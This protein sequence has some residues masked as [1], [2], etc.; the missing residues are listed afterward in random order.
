MARGELL[1]WLGFARATEFRFGYYVDDQ[2]PQ[3]RLNGMAVSRVRKDKVVNG[4]I[5]KYQ[6]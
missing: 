1:D 5:A 4:G 2:Y 3:L 6:P